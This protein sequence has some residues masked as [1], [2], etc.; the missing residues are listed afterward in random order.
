MSMPMIAHCPPGQAGPA[1]ASVA[2][3][4]GAGFGAALATLVGGGAAEHAPLADAGTDA[5]TDDSTDAGAQPGSESTEPQQAVDLGWRLP[6]RCDQRILGVPLSL[7]RP[8]RV[9]PSPPRAQGA[10][11]TGRCTARSARASDGGPRRQT[12][13]PLWCPAPRGPVAAAAPTAAR[14]RLPVPPWGGRQ[15]APRPHCDNAHRWRQPR[16]RRCGFGRCGARTRRRSC[17]ARARAPVAATTTQAAANPTVP[18]TTPP[19]ASPITAL[20]SSTASASRL[21][22]AGASADGN[23]QNAAS[24]AR[25]RCGHRS[26]CSQQLDHDEHRDCRPA[27]RRHRSARTSGNAAGPPAVHPGCGPATARIT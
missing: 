12:R 11:G 8:R 14:R 4:A 21:P 19:A 1:S 16:P 9:L 5:K 15:A 20:G 24:R 10:G 17:G 6:H 7:P 18:A 2:S 13:R 26:G 3:D 27:G 23:G 25:T 22:A